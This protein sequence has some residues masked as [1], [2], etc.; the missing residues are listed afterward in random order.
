MNTLVRFY[1][2]DDAARLAGVVLAEVT[3]VVAAA[4]L[5]ARAATRLGLGAAA[6]HGVWACAL[7]GVLLAPALAV[8]ASRSGLGLW[9]LP[10]PRTAVERPAAPRE[11]PEIEVEGLPDVPDRGP[12]RPVVATPAP[13]AAGP[14]AATTTRQPPPPAADRWRAI[15]GAIALA[16]GLGTLALLARLARG[17]RSLATLKRAARPIAHEPLD[18][19]LDDVR[20][21]LGRSTLPP[22]AEVPGLAGPLAGGLLQPVVLLPAGLAATLEPRAL[23]D[24]LIHECA[25]VARRD[26]A[27]G[28]LQR[29][30]E[31]AFWPHPLIHYLNRKLAR[32]REEVCDNFVLRAGDARSYAETLLGLSLVGREGLALGLWESNWNLEERVAGLLDPGRSLMTAWNRRLLAIAA[33]VLATAG[34]AVA[35]VRFIEP[36]ANQAAKPAEED[37]SKAKI[38]G[39]VVDEA[40]KPVAGAKI[41]SPYPY[42]TSGVTSGPDGRFTLTL[43][44][45]AA[46]YAGVIASTDD[47]ARQGYYRAP[48]YGPGTL[49]PVRI[50]LKPSRETTVTVKDG[51]GK[52]V[53]GAT[54]LAIGSP[55]RTAAEATT[56]AGGRARLRTPAE[57]AIESVF[58]FKPGAGADYYVDPKGRPTG[59][60]RPPLP[61]EVAL[62]FEGA[63]SVRVRA[64]DAQGRPLA[65]VEISPWYISKPGKAYIA[66]LSGCRATR[67]TTDAEGIVRFDWFPRDLEDRVQLSVGPWQRYDISERLV[68]NPTDAREGV[69]L[70]VVP[71]RTARLAGKVTLPDG[72]PAPGVLVQLE[73]NR[74]WRPY[75]RTSADGTYSSAVAPGQS[76]M[77]AVLDER[78]AA[79]TITGVVAREGET[80]SGLDFRLGPGT[81][82][83]GRV[84]VGPDAKPA[85]GKDITLIQDGG[86]VADAAAA[87]P[88]PGPRVDGAAEAFRRSHLVRHAT[89]DADGRYEFRVGPGEYRLGVDSQQVEQALTVRDEPAIARDF[90][91]ERESRVPVTGTVVDEAGKP[92]AGALVSS[93]PRERNNH[94][95]FETTADAEGRVAAERWSDAMLVLARD[96]RGDRAGFASLGPDDRE[97]RVTIKPALAVRG[98]AVDGAGKPRAGVRVVV[99]QADRPRVEGGYLRGPLIR[100]RTDADGRYTLRGVVPG[101]SAQVTALNDS[102]IAP[103]EPRSIETRPNASGVIDVPDIVLN[104]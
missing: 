73:G 76:Y 72:S 32:A 13:L 9:T 18:A 20:A 52:P 40:G 70:K 12:S 89:T 34:L 88:P 48:G 50:V 46:G 80:R 102:R 64:T 49:P 83:R 93:F 21:A 101:A 35:S 66:N 103:S 65:G 31:A 29:L 8:V 87:A 25:H 56:D 55:I 99:A 16:W 58:A 45:A 53:A 17:A 100:T 10:A 22:I 77:I 62:T 82:L 95:G 39:T 57:A 27:V 44:N 15:G 38:E 74:G 92:A 47:G 4:A 63:R 67:A 26:P 51:Q 14:V 97:F 24:V 85:V 94:A 11:R 36:A 7:V 71:L 33:L 54:V 28:L 98:R 68:Y 5:L 3:V 42:G 79:P 41:T 59:T 84:T 43:N 2:G 96:P 37:V 104:P 23:R 6:R 75:A 30:A 1:P 61:P 19:V 69:E 86:P 60:K 90:H 81:V 78:W 91:L